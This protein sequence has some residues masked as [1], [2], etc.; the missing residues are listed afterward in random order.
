MVGLILAV[1]AHGASTAPIGRVVLKCGPP[2]GDLVNG[3][4]ITV[5]R[6]KSSF[7]AQVVEYRKG[8]GRKQAFDVK[9]AR[10]PCP[11]AFEGRRLRLQVSDFS[12]S[13]LTQGPKRKNY[14]ATLEYK[15]TPEAKK[16]TLGVACQIL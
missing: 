16:K 10:C 4:Y 12:M 7:I 9:Q 3:T 14:L 1:Q 2:A 15:K 11:R 6:Q 5:N 13:W 8:Q